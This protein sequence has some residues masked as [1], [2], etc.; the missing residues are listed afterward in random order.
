MY[1]KKMIPVYLLWSILY[2]PL[3][4]EALNTL[5]IPLTTATIPFAILVGLCYTGT[6]YHLWYFPALFLAL[7]TMKTWKRFFSMRSLLVLSLL[8][9]C[10]GATETYFGVLPQ[11]LQQF[12]STFYFRIFYTTRNFLFFGLFYVSLGYLIAQRKKTYVPYSF[13]K[14]L[15][16]AFLLVVEVLILQPTERLDSNILLSCVP[17]C[18]Y[19]FITLLHMKPIIHYK[20]KISYR[21]YYKFYYFLHPFIIYMMTTF[22]FQ[23]DILQDHY[24]IQILIVFGLLQLLTIVLTYMKKKYP[25]ALRYL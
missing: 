24:W 11:P 7:I 14:M 10:L 5:E 2:L 20:P 8:L 12:L 1:I 21:D 18:Y 23:M 15:F 13:I 3:G 25:K 16:F 17:L 22:F 19:M 9:L 4:L 6:Y